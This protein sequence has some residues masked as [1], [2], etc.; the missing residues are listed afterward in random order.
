MGLKL[1]EEAMFGSNA[2][3]T[4]SSSG[5][6]K[7]LPVFKR[8]NKNRPRELS[9]KI[10]VPRVREVVHVKKVVKKDPRFDDA[11]GE[12]REDVSHYCIHQFVFKFVSILSCFFSL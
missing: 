3:Q 11:C 2:K 8:E 6:K 4:A 9:A 10:R 5:R 7:K 1:Y 12:L